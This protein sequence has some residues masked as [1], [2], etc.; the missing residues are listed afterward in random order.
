MFSSAQSPWSQASCRRQQ[1]WSLISRKKL[2]TANETVFS[3]SGVPCPC[4]FLLSPPALCHIISQLEHLRASQWGSAPSSLCPLVLLRTAACGGLLKLGS[5]CVFTLFQ[6][7]TWLPVSCRTSLAQHQQPSSASSACSVS[8]HIR[9]LFRPRNL[10]ICCS[11]CPEVRP[12]V[13][14]L[15][16]SRSF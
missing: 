3:K 14:Y 1:N 11:L 8:N 12:C 13:S 9:S 4:P 15:E 5:C 16:D 2:D 10:S 6:S 7:L